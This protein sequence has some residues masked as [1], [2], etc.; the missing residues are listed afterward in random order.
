MSNHSS[1][2][3]DKTDEYESPFLGPM[4]VANMATEEAEGVDPNDMIQGNST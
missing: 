2:K 1:I 4:S 3:T